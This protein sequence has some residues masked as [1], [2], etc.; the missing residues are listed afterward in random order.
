MGSYVSTRADTSLTLSSPGTKDPRGS[1]RRGT[2]TRNTL[3]P[4]R[5]LVPRRTDLRTPLP[6]NVF[7][8]GPWRG[9]FRRKRP[10]NGG[11][12]RVDPCPR[13]YSQSGG[14]G[15]DSWVSTFLSETPKVSPNPRPS[16]PGS[17][18]IGIVGRESPDPRTPR[19]R[20]QPTSYFVTSRWRG[21]QIPI[22]VVVGL[23][24][25]RARLGPV[26]N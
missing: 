14:E 20:R 10:R 25:G 11:H 13:V 22:T 12:T 16:D 4:T 19:L 2:E 9:P 1:G 18:H 17:P 7:V 24:S 8:S 15:R 23:S 26:G 5:L 6:G 21:R 3:V